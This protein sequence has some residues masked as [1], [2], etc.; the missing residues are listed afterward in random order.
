MNR[1][2]GI[3]LGILLPLLVLLLGWILAPQIGEALPPSGDLNGRQSVLISF[4]RQMDPESVESR[5]FLSPSISGEFSWNESFNQL[6]FTPHKAW[7]AGEIITFQLDAWARSRIRLPLLRQ[8]IFTLPVSPTLLTYLWPADGKSNLYLVNPESG[9]SQ[10]LTNEINGVLDY[11]ISADGELIFY[12][13]TTETGTSI[14]HALNRQT[15]STSEVFQ[16]TEGL[17]TTPRISPGGNLLALEYISHEPGVLPG[18]RIYNL[19]EKTQIDL[20]EANEYLEKPHWSPAGWLSYYSQTQKGYYFWNP[21]SEDTQFLPNET[22]G[23]GSWSADGRYFVCSEILFISDTLA[24]RHLQLYDLVAENL[25]DLSQG[26]FLEDLNPG[27]SP[28]GLTLAYSRKSLDPQEWTPGRQLW[29][30]DIESGEN[31]A[32]TESVDF[33]HTSFAW[34]PEANQLAYVRYNQAKLSDPP[35][36]WLINQ[37]GS[38]A[39]RLIINGFKPGWI[40]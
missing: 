2:V 39:M 32:L 17:C 26:N 21:E 27:F 4:T 9:D 5:F 3:I 38:E 16:C 35:E 19:I 14:I 20:G 7:P 30:M 22:G 15:V 36:I 8:F 11:N 25:Q 23:D 29:I 34:H 12:S 33:H 40:P 24:P 31:F 28:R 10:A 37:D 18:I 6:T 13:T 1:K